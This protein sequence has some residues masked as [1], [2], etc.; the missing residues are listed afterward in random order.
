MLVW[1]GTAV[2]TWM[3]F[4]LLYR[5][6]AT[7]KVSHVSNSQLNEDV[8]VP[9][10]ASPKPLSDI[11]VTSHHSCSEWTDPVCGMDAKPLTATLCLRHIFVKW[12]ITEQTSKRV[13]S[14][15]RL[16]YIRSTCLQLGEVSPQLSYHL[17]ALHKSCLNHRKTLT[18]LFVCSSLSVRI[19]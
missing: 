17:V 7:I 18:S 2:S 4:C 6:S 1:S 11:T 14:S 3:H 8:T 16:C 10:L 19:L 5:T 12:A 13:S 9:T 15:K